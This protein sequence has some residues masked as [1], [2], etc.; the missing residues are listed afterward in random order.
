MQPKI[1]IAYGKYSM[2]EMNKITFFKKDIAVK[3]LEVPGVIYESYIT[4]E[5][6]KFSYDKAEIRFCDNVS[7]IY[8]EEKIS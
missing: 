7:T 3:S 5:I 6:K 1:V 8:N 2:G 4:S